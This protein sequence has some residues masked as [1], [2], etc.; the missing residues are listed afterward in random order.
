MSRPK[1]LAYKEIRKCVNSQEKNQQTSSKKSILDVRIRD[2]IVLGTVVHEMK[3]KAIRR[4][5]NPNTIPSNEIKT[6]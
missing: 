3:I 4:E 2:L 6:T 5:K 1:I